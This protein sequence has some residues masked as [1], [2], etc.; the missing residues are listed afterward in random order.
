MGRA[1]TLSHMESPESPEGA[2]EETHCCRANAPSPPHPEY[3]SDPRER[4]GVRD[5]ERKDRQKERVKEG[6]RERQ[7]A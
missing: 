1:E 2:T 5:T 6:Q 4:R 3:A 7:R